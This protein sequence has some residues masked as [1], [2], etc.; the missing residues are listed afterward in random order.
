MSIQTQIYILLF[1]VL[2]F[3]TNICEYSLFNIEILY[4]KCFLYIHQITEALAETRNTKPV[5][6]IQAPLRHEEER[7]RIGKITYKKQIFIQA[8]IRQQQNQLTVSQSTQKP[9][10]G[11]NPEQIH[12][13]L[14]KQQNNISLHILAQ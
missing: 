5:I 4:T 8:V 9:K 11:E 6:G 14:Y 10:A 2:L 3:F 13:Y 12:I 1:L 7:K